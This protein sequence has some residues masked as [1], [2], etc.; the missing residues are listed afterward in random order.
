MF[1]NI[2]LVATSVFIGLLVLNLFFRIKLLKLYRKLLEG[3]VDFPPSYLFN[4]KKLKEEVVPRYP[5]Y[6][7]EIL[8]FSGK[9][10]TSIRIAFVVFVIS[11]II[12]YTYI[13]NR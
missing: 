9:L 10:N 8:E 6:E 3:R 11:L 4:K 12:G 2:I 1:E 5:A 13:K 7:K